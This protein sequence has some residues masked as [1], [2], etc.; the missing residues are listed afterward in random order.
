MFINAIEN[1]E[2]DTY[3]AEKIVEDKMIFN[4]DVVIG[5]AASGNTPFTCKVLEKAKNQN[6]LLL[7]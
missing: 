5:L 1:A 3:F 6:A 7:Q 2:D 4:E